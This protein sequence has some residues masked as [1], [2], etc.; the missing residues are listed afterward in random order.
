MDA[1]STHPELD[2]FEWHKRAR[3]DLLAARALANA[4]DYGDRFPAHVCFHCQQCIEKW[5]KSIIVAAGR[6]A[7]RTH[8]V[9][10]LLDECIA[11]QPTLSIFLGKVSWLTP[12]AAEVRYP[13]EDD[14]SAIDAKRAI[15]LAEKVQNIVSD[16]FQEP[17][18]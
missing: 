16:F 6:K 13:H 14:V 4:V 7:S 2:P 9:K 18:S 15:E 10:A 17:Q 3:D 1:S 11:L 8:D 12:F 5:L